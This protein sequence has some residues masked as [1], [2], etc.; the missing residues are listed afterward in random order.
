ME[1]TQ[2]SNRER[3]EAMYT[4]QEHTMPFGKH[5]GK[6]LGEVPSG[7]LAWLIREFKLSSGLRAA[8]P[9]ELTRRNVDTPP[10]PPTH[11]L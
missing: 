4:Q 7:Y 9:D 6:P 2:L 11:P 5:A 1:A 3:E 10:P 8:V